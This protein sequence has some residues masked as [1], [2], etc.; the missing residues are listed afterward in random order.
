LFGSVPFIIGLAVGIS[1]CAN[2]Q[3]TDTAI[4]AN[5]KMN[6]DEPTTI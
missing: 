4:I 2:A 3:L 1:P 5:A 6:L